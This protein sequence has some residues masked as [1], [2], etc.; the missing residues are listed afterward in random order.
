[1]EILKDSLTWVALAGTSLVFVTLLSH[2]YS[3]S[4]KQVLTTVV[5]SI[6]IH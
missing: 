6:K 5:F 4:N 1:M 3:N 2:S